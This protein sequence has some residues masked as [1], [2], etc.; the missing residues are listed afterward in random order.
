[1]DSSPKAGQMLDTTPTEIV[2]T[3]NEGVG[4]IFFKILDR[5]GKEVGNPG[6]IKLDGLRMLLPLRDKLANG[7]YIFTY[8]VIS[9]DTHPVGTT[10]GFSIGEPM[11]DAASLTAAADQGKTAWTYAVAANRW[12]L[13]STMLLAVGSALF[14]LVLTLSAPVAARAM[15]LGR[16]AAIIA[17]VSYIAG[18]GIGGAEMQMGGGSA[19][20]AAKSW[21]SGLASTLAPSAAIGVP[22]MLLL[23]W[24]VGKGVTPPR[25][26]ALAVGTA[27]GVASFLVTGH[28]ATAAP[29]WLMATTVGLHLFGTAFWLGA[30]YPLYQSTK[31]QSVRES[32]ALMTQFSTRAVYAVAAIVLSGAIISWTQLTSFANF[33]GNDYGNALLRKLL[34]FVVVLAIA[35]WNKIKLTPAMERDDVTAAARMRRSIRIEYLLFILILGVA[36]SLTL[37]QPPR[38]RVAQAAGAAA[39]MQM[40]VD[41]IKKTVTSTAG[42]SLDIELTP[43]KAGENMLMATVKDPKGQVLMNLA[44][45][46]IVASL[47]SAGISEIRLKGAKLPNGQWH[48]MIKEMLIPGEWTMGA[49]AFITDFDKVEFATKLDIK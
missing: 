25:S 12:L 45:L 1:M 28:A 10:F 8:R 2:A 13:Y 43:A 18:I 4:P 7:T 42:Y 41:G 47:E 31:L 27:A 24:S 34:L 32:G 3:F 33:F 5:T 26:G 21:S 40:G 23:I 19:L 6:E 22:A 44:D 14:V 49:D 20:L 30:L 9:A 15:W 46:E 35:A 48:V 29:V 17:A 36:M 37:T 16:I 38:A 11:A 39:G